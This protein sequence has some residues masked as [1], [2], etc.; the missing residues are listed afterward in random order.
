MR[1]A[2]WRYTE[3]DSGRRGRELYDQER[4]PY[5]RHNLAGQAK[6]AGTISELKKSLG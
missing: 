2:Q 1:T 5:E 3:W 6:Y 4:D